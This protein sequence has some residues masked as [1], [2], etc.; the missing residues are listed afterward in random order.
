M[1]ITPPAPL[2]RNPTGERELAYHD[3]V[4]HARQDNQRIRRLVAHAVVK[5]QSGDVGGA[6]LEL[7]MV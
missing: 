2:P 1:A 6:L 7:E 3:N 4:W 5:L